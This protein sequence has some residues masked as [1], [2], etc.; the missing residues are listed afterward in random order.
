MS[1]EAGERTADARLRA[2]A[3]HHVDGARMGLTSCCVVTMV[4]SLRG[5]DLDIWRDT[6]SGC[7]RGDSDV[8]QEW[9]RYP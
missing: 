9:C 5:C 8:R 3:L 6:R 1:G 2:W 4:S 7:A